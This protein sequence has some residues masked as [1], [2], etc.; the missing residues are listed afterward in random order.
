M[1]DLETKDL[2][3]NDERLRDVVALS[4]MPAMWLGAEPLRIAESLAATLFTTVG[5]EFVYVCLNNGPGQ[6][7]IA[8]AQIARTEASPALA[9][10]LGS[11]LL[12][13]ARAHDPDELM[14][15]PNPI[16][17]GALRTT[18]RPLAF[19]AECGLIAAGFA[20]DS[21]PDAFQHLLLNVAATQATIAV[22]NVR[23][24]CSL[25]QN[26][27][28][29]EQSQTRE[30]QAREEVRTLYGVSH[31]LAELNLEKLVQSVTDAATE[32]SGAAFGSFFYNV[33]DERG[34]AYM[35]YTLSGA[36]REA[37]AD[38]P[39]PRNTTLFAPTFAGTGVVRLDD[40]H[41]A[42][43]FGDNHPYYGLPPDH[44]P[45]CSYLA[46]PVIS[47][48]DEVLGGLFFGHPE[49]GVFTER[50]ERIVT[51]IAAQAAIAIDNARLYQAAQQEIAERKQ[52]E[53][54]LR[55]TERHLRT[56]SETHERRVEARTAELQRQAAR[57]RR[58]A[59]ELTS[60]EQRERKHL[61]AILHDGLQ[62]LLVAAKMRLAQARGWVRD[63]A[64]A[65][66][67]EG[68][69]DLLSQAVD[70]SRSLTRQLRPPVLYEDGLLSAL[71]WLASELPKLHDLH[72]VIDAED[73]EPLLSD[74]AKVLLFESVRELL[75][76]VAKHAGVKEAA[77][78]VRQGGQ[79]LQIA[80]ED[81][82]AGFDVEAVA[83]EEDP[84][85]LGFGL[86]SIRERLAALGGDMA[87]ESVPG[88]GACI[89]LAI[90]LAPAGGEQ[91]AA[92]ATLSAA[93]ARAQT[94]GPAT[95]DRQTRVLVVD[96]HTIVREGI[97]NVLSGDERLVVVGEAADGVEAIKAVERHQPDVVLIDVNMPRMNGVEATREIRRR[98]P[99]VRIVALS[100]QDDT[101]T[102]KT[103][104]R[105]GA[106]AF[107]SKSDDAGQM[108]HA[109]LPLT[110]EG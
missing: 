82:G 107:V 77:V 101:A 64:V 42:P 40:V 56:L 43:R 98:W 31:T 22:Q 24:L 13:W 44:L 23:L 69:A 11:A 7:P 53:R 78:R 72:V 108:I 55:E 89:K 70:A 61:A 41:K 8:V 58:L 59:G 87:M 81:K 49:P 93:A 75:F 86:F 39:M 106:T 99:E 34:E 102:A 48:S 47:R 91:A 67:I 95:T 68:V 65:S 100:V 62:Q 2:R 5:A 12:E 96:D 85:Q 10:E 52:A 4:T 104:I 30:R 79:R 26:V 6:E 92:Q 36:P 28:E 16:G 32:L 25:R 50:S 103:M 38:S 109:V 63:P 76:N 33:V 1:L 19:G 14:L 35:L 71:R 46:V 57:L 97:A 84:Q 110:Q 51:G 21:S 45:V 17:S 105:A 88:D 60:A 27:T 3:D 73:A 90:P 94:P 29:K 66:A 20:D 54:A 80:V 83:R 74:D 37:F 15:V 9:S 18:I